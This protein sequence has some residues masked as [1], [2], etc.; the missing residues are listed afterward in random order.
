MPNIGNGSTVRKMEGGNRD[1]RQYSDEHVH[2]RKAEALARYAP[3]SGR[4]FGAI[5]EPEVLRTG[6]TRFNVF[7]GRQ[8]TLESVFT[9]CPS[10][11]FREGMLLKP[12]MVFQVKIVRNKTQMQ[13]V[14][15]ATAAV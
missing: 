8:P 12:N 11:A 1:W 10:I 5:V 7:R 13:E 15:E 2:R 4:G 3:L 9:L 6:R 14:A